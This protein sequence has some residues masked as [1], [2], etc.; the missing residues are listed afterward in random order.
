VSVEERDDPHPEVS[1]QVIVR[2]AMIE[3]AVPLRLAPM[4]EIGS[5]SCGGLELLDDD[6][7]D[8]TFVS[9]SLESWCRTEN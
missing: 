6:L 2:E 8:P 5:S 4:P 3:D 9:L 7:I 1:T